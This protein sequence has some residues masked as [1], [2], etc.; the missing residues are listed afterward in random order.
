MKNTRNLI[1]IALAFLFLAGCSNEIYEDPGPTSIYKV[2]AD[3]SDLVELIP[4]T[5]DVEYWGPA[6]SPDGKLVAFS[7]I[8]PHDDDFPQLAI[9]NSD[10]A[11]IIQLTDND[12][13][14]YLPAWSPDSRTIVFVS[15]TNDDTGNR[16]SAELYRIDIDG[17]NE[18]RLTDNDAFEY[19]ASF[20]PDGSQIVF[21]SERGDKWQIYTMNADGNGQT[22]L[23]TS[24]RGNAPDWSP[25]GTQFVFTSDRDGDDDVWIMNIDG[26]GQR[27]LTNDLTDS[28]AWDDNPRWSPDGRYIVFNSWLDDIASVKILDLETMRLI[29]L[30]DPDKLSAVI[31]TWSPEGQQVLF[32][33]SEI[34]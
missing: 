19:G 14:N 17:S 8:S 1:L 16:D 3:G 28:E 7:F 26:S 31:P 5:P 4:A 25:D 32:T 30:H 24:A 15:Q 22:P 12:R 23:S 27:N 18:I 33:A 9:A 29:D 20:S 6:W 2:S 13:S 21:G 11:N 34:E 10:G